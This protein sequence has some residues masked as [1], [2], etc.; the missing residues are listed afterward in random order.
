MAIVDLDHLQNQCR[1]AQAKRLIRE[2][3]DAYR[4]GAYRASVIMTWIAVVYDIIEKLRE[5]ALTGDAYATAKVND[6]DQIQKDGDLEKSLAF[7]RN[8]LVEAK[9]SLD[10]ITAQEKSDLE[11]LQIDRNR[12]AH[13]NLIREGEAFAPSAEQA[14]A[15]L[16]NAVEILLSRPPVQGKAALVIIHAEVD[17]SYFPIDENDAFTVLQSSPIARGKNNLIKDFVRGALSSCVKEELPERKLRQRVAAFRAVQRLHPEVV[18]ADLA[19]WFPAFLGKTKDVDYPRLLVLLERAPELEER[20]DE[21]SS[22][23]LRQF[24]ENLPPSEEADVIPSV[25]TLNSLHGALAT[26]LDAIAAAVDAIKRFK[27]I[28]EKFRSRGQAIPPSVLDHV[29]SQYEAAGSFDAANTLASEVI[30]PSAKEF[31]KDQAKRIIAAY[32]NGQVA[33]SFEFSTALSAIKMS[34]VLSPEEFD[35]AINSTSRAYKLTGYMHN[36]PPPPAPAGSPAPPQ[37]VPE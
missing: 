29:V 14:R 11:R 16:R 4:V 6:F 13:P 33:G 28:C 25:S 1:T 22:V 7:E 3:V 17:S 37:I 19:A 15:H 32:E 27:L 24:V 5:V 36:P 2:A 34:E 20:I 35:A 18:S 10:L 26:K 31:S 21:A 23:R 8:I 12:S 30:T 9:D